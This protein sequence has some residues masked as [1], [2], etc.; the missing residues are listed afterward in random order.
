MDI[1]NYV[2]KLTGKVEL[3]KPLEIG[4]SYNI[5]FDGEIREAKDSSNDDG[6]LTRTYTFMPILG[7]IVGEN[8]EVTKTKDARKRSQ[9]LRATIRREWLE[10]NDSQLDEN[11][12]Y[13]K[14]MVGILNAVI[15]GKI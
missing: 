6:T 8:G 10:K 12:Y 7:D 14:R 13:D 5:Y 2:L 11:M 1:S 3:K 9:Q 15:E 4:K